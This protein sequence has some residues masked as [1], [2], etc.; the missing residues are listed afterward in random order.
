MPPL[1]DRDAPSVPP[2]A[3]K[4]APAPPKVGCD[5]TGTLSE[6]AL[7]TIHVRGKLSGARRCRHCSRLLLR[8]S[9]FVSV[10]GEGLFR[11]KVSF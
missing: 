8:K 7:C 10:P 6:R 11:K 5:V 9:R 4:P 1:V 3:P 2:P